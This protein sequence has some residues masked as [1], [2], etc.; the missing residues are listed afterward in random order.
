MVCH[1]R[2]VIILISYQFLSLLTNTTNQP[3]QR[4]PAGTECFKRVSAPHLPLTTSTIIMIP[5]RPASSARNRTMAAAEDQIKG[6]C[7]PRSQER[8]AKRAGTRA[9]VLGRGRLT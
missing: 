8:K 3:S 6:A 9:K 4:S 2:Q 1:S 5:S 7:R